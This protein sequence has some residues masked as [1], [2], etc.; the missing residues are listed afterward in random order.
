MRLLFALPLTL[1]LAAPATAAQMSDGQLRKA[2]WAE[3]GF[4]SQSANNG[5]GNLNRMVPQIDACVARKRQ[6]GK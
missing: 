3:A 4:N 6:Q 1:V 2:C 5:R